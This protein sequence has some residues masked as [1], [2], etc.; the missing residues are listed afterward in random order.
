MPYNKDPMAKQKPNINIVQPTT[1]VALTVLPKQVA[2]LSLPQP[3]VTAKVGAQIE[4]PVKVARLFNFAGEFKVQVTLPKDVKGLSADETTVP[5]G[6]DEATLVVHVA[7]D[8]AP[9]NVADIVVRATAMQNGTVPTVHEAK[10]TVN[11]V[12]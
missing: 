3:A 4:V 6:K 10:L 1:P 2:T 7:P 12:K 5:A 11:V 8:M 9:A